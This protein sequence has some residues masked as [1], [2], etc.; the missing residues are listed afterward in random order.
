MDL[1]EPTYQGVL[2]EYVALDEYVALATSLRGEARTV[3]QHYR[4]RGDVENNFDELKNQWGSVGFMT[5]EPLAK[6]IETITI[7]YVLKRGVR[8]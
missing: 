4:D 6:S 5:Q 1:P 8:A 3:A 7:I 2:Y